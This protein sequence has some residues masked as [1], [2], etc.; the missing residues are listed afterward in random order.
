MDY[1][2]HQSVAHRSDKTITTTH[3]LHGFVCAECGGGYLFPIGKPIR[4][5][6]EVII[7]GGTCPYCQAAIAYELTQWESTRRLC[8]VGDCTGDGIE[9]TSLGIYAGRYCDAHYATAFPLRKDGPE[10]YDYRDAGEHYDED[11]L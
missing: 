5:D 8:C 11:G 2:L 9:R 6:V 3:H 10:G 4:S 7:A 1:I